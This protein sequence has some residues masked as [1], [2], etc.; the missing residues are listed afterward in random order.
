MYNQWSLNKTESISLTYEAI[1]QQRIR[2][3]AWQ[4]AG[5]YLSDFLNLFRAPGESS[6]GGASTFIYRSHPSKPNDTLMAT[7]YA[8]MLGK[9]LLGEPMFADLTVKI[10]LENSLRSDIS[11]LGGSFPSAFSG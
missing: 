11:Y 10:R 1:R 5:E 9:V 7:N 6:S 3:F 8:F 4:Y 2:C